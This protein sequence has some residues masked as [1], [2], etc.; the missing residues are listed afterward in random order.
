MTTTLSCL[1]S[2]NTTARLDNVSDEIDAIQSVAVASSQRASSKVDSSGAEVINLAD[3]D[4]ANAN[5]KT[6]FQSLTSN[7]RTSNRPSSTTSHFGSSQKRHKTGKNS[8]QPMI[9]N[10]AP[11]PEAKA[12]MDVAVADMIHS[13]SMPFTFARDLK[14][15][16]VINL[17]RTLPSD[18]IT[19]DRRAVG[20]KLLKT[21]YTINW[22]EGIT[23]LVADSKLYG[24]SIFGDGATIKNI[25]MINALAAGVNNPFCLLDV[26]DCSEHC[27]K[28]GKKDAA[29]HA[30]LFLSLIDQLENT[31][32]KNVRCLWICAQTV[33]FFFSLIL[34]LSF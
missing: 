14:F 24:V 3:N 15:M 5:R 8:Y 23:M 31:M 7:I 33:S 20:G 27:S 4:N 19:P 21:L 9:W 32:D 18:Y 6:L 30:K 25:P 11:D 2:E 12:K 34:F 29:Y 17:A 28:A 26:F 22:K 13:N 16:K 1:Y 10:G